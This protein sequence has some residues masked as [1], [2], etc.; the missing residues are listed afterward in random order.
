M[1]APA[2]DDP[3]VRRTRQALMD[4][5]WTLIENCAGANVSIAEIARQAGVSRQALYQH[6]H[7]REAL[8]ADAAIRRMDAALTES[9]GQTFEQKAE[10]LLRHLRASASFYRA[11]MGTSAAGFC[12]HLEDY[13]AR[14]FAERL[15]S[16]HPDAL[17]RPDDAGGIETLA[18]FIA[19]GTIVFIRRWL[20][21]PAEDA[22]SPA[23]AARQLRSVTDPFFGSSSRPSWRKVVRDEGT[24]QECQ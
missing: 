9:G 7:D 2:H 23:E 10:A 15:R 6:Y 18:R 4:A 11:V 19:G 20:A 1:T 16:A 22:V 5:T 12:Q 21:Q 17:V 3:R 24:L 8:L 14:Q 13:M